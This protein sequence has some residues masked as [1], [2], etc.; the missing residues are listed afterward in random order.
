[1]RF[2]TYPLAHAYDYSVND[3]GMQLLSS[4]KAEER[5]NYYEEHSVGWV[6]RPKHDPRAEY[7]FVRPGKF[8]KG[9]CQPICSSVI[10]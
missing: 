9:T 3:D 6:G 2:F 7:P 4:D 8:K 10:L 5:R 1:M